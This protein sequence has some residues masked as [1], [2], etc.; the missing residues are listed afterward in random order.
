MNIEHLVLFGVQGKCSVEFFK[1]YNGNPLLRGFVA[2]S[3]STPYKIMAFNINF[4]N[5]YFISIYSN[6]IVDSNLLSND[7]Y[8]MQFN[9]NYTIDY[10]IGKHLVDNLKDSYGNCSSYH[11]THYKRCFY[12]F[13]STVTQTSIGY[14]FQAMGT[15]NLFKFSVNKTIDICT[16]CPFPTISTSYDYNI[17]DNTFNVC[18]ALDRKITR[19]SIINVYM[20]FPIEESRNLDLLYSLFY[21]FQ[22]TYSKERKKIIPLIFPTSC[23]F[24]SLVCYRNVFQKLKDDKTEISYLIA[25]IRYILSLFFF[26][27]YVTIVKN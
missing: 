20:I 6:D 13:P 19:K 1:L 22:N 3:H 24:D 26:Y 14:N 12:E 17:T 11:S 4:D 10:R 25:P 15:P 27:Y 5:F 8:Y 21:L 2:F 16:N 18:S 7:Y 9:M 23:S